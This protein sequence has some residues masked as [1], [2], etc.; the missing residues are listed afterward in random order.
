MTASAFDIAILG[1]GPVGRVLALML[2]RVAPDPARIALLAGAAPAPA[3][4]AAAVP[5]ADPRVLAMNHGSRVLLESLHAWPERSADIRNIHVSQRGRLGRTV[6]QNTDFGVPQLGSVVAYSGLHAKLD[7]CV[8]ASGVT[9]LTGPAAQVGSQDADGVRIMQGGET[10]R[11]QVAVQS[12][13]AGATDLRRDYGQHAVLT[14]AHATLPRRGWAWERFT[15]EGPLALLPHPQTPDAYS[16]VWCSAPDRAAELA[17]LDNAA[18]SKALSA[19]FGDRL[20]RLS[21]QAPRHVFPLALAARRAQVQGR[22]AAIG[23]AAQT[24]HPV[25]GQGLNLGLRDAARLA[26]ALAGWLARPEASPTALLA[27]FAQARQVDRVITAGLTDLMPR[28]FAT[29]LAPVEHA[30]GL[31]L[32]GMDLASPLRAPLAQHL[33]QGFRA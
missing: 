16:V 4:P 7:E 3:M 10:L 6:I 25:A 11:C 13:G 26:Q 28:V 24:L 1:A 19:A 17:A 31:A 22:V 30:C 15:A 8:A 32:L 20:G 2:A 29:G 12:D 27:E 14:T 21:S 9:V 33:L 18:F 5:A 23:N